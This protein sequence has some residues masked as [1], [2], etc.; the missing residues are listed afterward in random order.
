MK[1][2]AETSLHSVI[3]PEA[4]V[5]TL[6]VCPMCGLELGTTEIGGKD[7]LYCPADLCEFVHW[8]NPKPVTAT[9]IALDGGLVLVKRKFEPYVGDWCLPGGFIEATEHPSESACREVL[10]ETGLT[11]SQP[12]LVDAHSPGRG[13]NV[14]ILF[15]VAT[16][17]SGIP[18]AGDD[19]SEVG[20]FQKD[21]L[22][23]NVAF[24]LHRNII[25]RYFEG[26]L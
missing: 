4:R 5:D 15:Y 22:P 13:I 21:S 23:P 1:A 8:D 2:P 18:I 25:R 7:R 11:I 10:E 20:V 6:K 26:K 3:Y 16:D 14:V 19:A 24:E 12:R 9:L 17:A